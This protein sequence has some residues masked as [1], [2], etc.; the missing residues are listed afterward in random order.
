MACTRCSATPST[1]ISI[2]G[3]ETLAYCLIVAAT[4][5]LGICQ[6][7]S[8]RD[9]KGTRVMKL[10]EVR[11]TRGEIIAMVIALGLLIFAAVRETL[12]A[13]NP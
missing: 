3:A 1:G 11:F 5:R 2:G 4:V 12:M 13:M 7:A 10:R 9:L 6:Y 8:W